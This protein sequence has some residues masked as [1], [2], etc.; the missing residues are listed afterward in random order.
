[1]VILATS[2]TDL[3]YDGRILSNMKSLIN[4]SQNVEIVFI[5]LPNETTT[6]R[7]TFL[8]TV[9]EYNFSFRRVLA[10]HPIFQ[11]ITALLFSIFQIVAIL[12]YKP[13]IVLVHDRSAALGPLILSY[14]M[15]YSLVYDDHEL[16]ERPRGIYSRFWFYIEKKIILR[17]RIN[18]TANVYRQR[19]IATLFKLKIK[20][21]VIENIPFITPLPIQVANCR[22]I[23]DK[24]NKIRLTHKIILHQGRIFKERGLDEIR[25][26]VDTLPTDWKLCLM[27]APENEVESL[28]SIV[29][30]PSHVVDLGFILYEEL[31]HIW[32]RIQ[33]AIIIYKPEK[34]NNR[35]CAPNRL[36][37]ALS[38]GVPL[39][40]NSDNPV[41]RGTIRKYSNGYA[42][43]KNTTETIQFF[44]NFVQYRRNAMKSMHEYSY[45]NVDDILN[46]LYDKLISDI[47]NE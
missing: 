34:I 15:K 18:L 5:N 1:M 26:I 23:V 16:F 29:K 38:Y 3:K 44:E 20:P 36:Y 42:F 31:Q 43:G 8:F 19:I 39:L 17:A 9:I 2:K 7:H 40:V 22:N 11:P 47:V 35:Y 4:T 14:F 30:K 6:E 24:I 25:Q 27:G 32:S 12:K 33:G 46:P 13:R 10:R 21:T 41:L 37:F 45:Q 28:L